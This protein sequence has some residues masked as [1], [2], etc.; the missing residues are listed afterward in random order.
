LSNTF[1]S[2]QP[3]LI[4]TLANAGV[5]LVKKGVQKAPGVITTNVAPVIA[6]ATGMPRTTN[7]QSKV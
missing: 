7:N 6:S 3:K 2:N 1:K 4:S 5:N